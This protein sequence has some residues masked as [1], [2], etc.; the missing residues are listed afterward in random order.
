MCLQDLARRSFWQDRAKASW[1]IFQVLAR[2]IIC[3]IEQDDLANT[4]KNEQDQYY[5]D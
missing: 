1:K 4:C 5:Q 3:K 2:P